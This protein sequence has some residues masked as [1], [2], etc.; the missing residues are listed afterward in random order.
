[1]E[2]NKI[3]ELEDIVN[4]SLEIR[5]AYHEL[6]QKHHG[7]IW[8]VEEDTLAFLTDVGLVG[9]LVMSHEGRWPLTGNE[10]VEL[11]HKLG[12]VFWWIVVLTHRC[13]M[14]FNDAITTFFEI[15]IKTLN[16][17]ERVSQDV[18]ESYHD[19]ERAFHEIIWSIEEDALAFLTDAGLIGRNI[20]S[21]Q[22]RW[23]KEDTSSELLHKLGE[24]IWWIAVLALRSKLDIKECVADFISKT[25]VR[26]LINK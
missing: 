5:V 18:R 23:P 13:S 2:T 14:N 7:S 17:V 8:T 26:L 3:I 20:M 24:C 6:E 1:M 19:A 15:D 16:E 22:G 21:L 4:R 12:E 25:E 10:K 9:R 11:K